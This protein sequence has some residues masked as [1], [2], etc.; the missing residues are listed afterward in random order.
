MTWG[1]GAGR[2]NSECKGS[3]AEKRLTC[4]RKRKNSG[5]EAGRM[6]RGVRDEASEEGLKDPTRRFHSEN[7]VTSHRGLLSRL[8]T[9]PKVG[10]KILWLHLVTVCRGIGIEAGI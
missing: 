6:A 10:F 3:E 1:Q 5:L 8:V 2:G 4:K 9:W 7:H